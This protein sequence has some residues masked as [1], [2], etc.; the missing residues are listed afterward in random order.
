[1]TEP[2]TITRTAPGGSAAAPGGWLAFGGI[3]MLIVVLSILR[4]SL[5]LGTGDLALSTAYSSL[6][7]LTISGITAGASVGLWVFGRYGRTLFS[8]LAG[9]ATGALASAAVLLV[10]GVPGAAVAV[11]AAVLALAG[12]IGGVL[13][14]IRPIEIVRG[15]ITATLMALLVFFLVA[16]NSSWLLRVFGDDGTQAARESANGLLAGAQALTVGIL[17]GLIAFWV[18][19]RSRATVRWPAYLLAGGMTGLLWIVGDLVTRIGTA[20]L[21]ALA[22]SDTAGDQAFQ[23]GLEYARINTGLVLFFVGAIT[24]MIAFGRTLP[25]KVESD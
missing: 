13:T 19:R 8:V 15:G 11:M 12:A 23:R 6:P 21:L 3:A 9:A 22:T 4:R 2:A 20:R 7:L 24:A 14:A 17:G 18:I 16:F 1:M 25:K 5:S 10:R